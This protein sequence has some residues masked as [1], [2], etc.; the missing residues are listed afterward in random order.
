MLS[1]Q[2]VVR[3][4]KHEGKRIVLE[5]GRFLIGREQDCN[6]R[7]SSDLVSRH[8]CVFQVDDYTVRLRDLGST[9]GTLVNGER[10]SGERTLAAGDRVVVGKLTF[11]VELKEVADEQEAAAAGPSEEMSL[12][13]DGA[14]T[15]YELPVSQ[16]A[17]SGQGGGPIPGPNPNDTAMIPTQQGYPP[18]GYGYP[19]QYPPPGYNPYA[20]PGY[21]PP[22]YGYPPQYGQYPPPGA[23]PPPESGDGSKVSAPPVKLPPPPKR[24]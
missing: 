20:Q 24:D 13:T 14:D 19:P 12:P 4:G 18:P 23:T 10:L 16:G 9:N 21:P 8:H 11:E 22:G 15:S 2:L 5:R 6:L 17:E 7:P 3:G 1:A